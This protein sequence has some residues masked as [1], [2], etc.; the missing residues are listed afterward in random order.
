[1]F[2]DTEAGAIASSIFYSLMKYLFQ[3]IPIANTLEDIES[4]A[5]ISLSIKSFSDHKA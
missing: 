3:E 5:D 2:S 1:M 4:L